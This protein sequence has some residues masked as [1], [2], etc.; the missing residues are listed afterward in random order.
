VLLYAFDPYSFSPSRLERTVQTRGFLEMR[1]RAVP[2]ACLGAAS[3]V[4]KP[5]P[6]RRAAALLEF[7]PSSC[8]EGGLRRDRPKLMDPSEPS[9]LAM[10]QVPVIGALLGTVGQR[11]SHPGV[12]GLR[13]APTSKRIRPRLGRASHVGRSSRAVRVPSEV[14]KRWENS[15]QTSSRLHTTAGPSRGLV[16]PEGADHA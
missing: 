4:V 13:H 5:T 9:Y 14:E 15:S 6:L 11:R 2:I 7:V 1:I 12:A 3:T 8:G 16:E 10:C